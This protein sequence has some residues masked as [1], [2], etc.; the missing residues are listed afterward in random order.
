MDAT[1]SFDEHI[2]SVT[3]ARLSSL[4]QINRVKHILDRNTLLT[5]SVPWSL[6]NSIIVHQSGLV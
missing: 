6:A 3:S 4:S 5:L 2:I 1:L